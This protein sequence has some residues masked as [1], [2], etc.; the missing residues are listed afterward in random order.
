MREELARVDGRGSRPGKTVTQQW[1]G[2]LGVI[3]KT[4]QKFIPRKKKYTKGKG[5]VLGPQ[6][7]MVCIN[8]QDKGTESIVTMIADDSKVNGR[9]GNVEEEGKLQKDL[10]R[11]RERTK[12]W[13]MENN[14][15]KCG[16]M[17]F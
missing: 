5:S 4:M 11:L 14:A 12:K 17:H 2:F 3:Q 9:T 10:D 16:V 7:F 13:Q 15:G 8:N 1:Q 6:L